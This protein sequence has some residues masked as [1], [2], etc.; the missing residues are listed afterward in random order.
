MSVNEIHK[1]DTDYDG[2]P[3]HRGHTVEVQGWNSDYVL[4]VIRSDDR[5][6][7]AIITPA[8]LI[9]LGEAAKREAWRY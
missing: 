5:T 4:L 6:N 1:V 8:E 7:E 3:A 9:E 2:R